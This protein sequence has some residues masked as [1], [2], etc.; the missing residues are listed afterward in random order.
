MT[1]VNSVLGSLP[2]YFFSLFR[3]PAKVIKKLEGIRRTFLWGGFDRSTGISWTK[4]DYV[5]APKDL[6]GLG[7][8]RLKDANLARLSK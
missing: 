6:G 5:V 1:L 8:R 3:A 7:V 4:W 2:L